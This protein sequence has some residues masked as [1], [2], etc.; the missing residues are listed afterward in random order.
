MKRAQLL[1]INLAL[2]VLVVFASI[3]ASSQCVMCKATAAGSEDSIGEGLN[4][5]ILYLMA[6]PYLLF[7]ILGVV[8]FR[9]KLGAFFKEMG[10]SY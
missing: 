9:K 8:F 3:D 4:R 10:N 6:A 5:G 2:L 1:L 7:L